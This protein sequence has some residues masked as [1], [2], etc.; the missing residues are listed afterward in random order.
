MS[1]EY[2]K[3]VREVYAQVLILNSHLMEKKTLEKQPFEVFVGKKINEMFEKLIKLS[4]SPIVGNQQKLHFQKNF[5]Q[6]LD[7]ITIYFNPGVIDQLTT[8]EYG[9]LYRE[10]FK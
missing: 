8:E 9:K 1:D 7:M 2:D 10:K 4:G 5:G 3:H 6:L